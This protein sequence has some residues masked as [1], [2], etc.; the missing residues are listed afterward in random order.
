MS[1]LYR[2]SHFTGYFCKAQ[3]VSVIEQVDG[4]PGD[5]SDLCFLRRAPWNL[6]EE[7]VQW[8]ERENHKGQEERANMEES[9]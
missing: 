2:K 5:F 4:Q 7:L 9:H 3:T 6:T 1:E 8:E